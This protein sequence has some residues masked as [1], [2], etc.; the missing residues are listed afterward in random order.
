MSR[1]LALALGP[2]ARYLVRNTAAEVSTLPE[3]CQKLAESIPDERDR[4]EF[5]KYCA[6]GLQASPCGPGPAD[7]PLSRPAAAEGGSAPVAFEPALLH[8]MKKE[9]AHY[10]GPMAGLLVEQAARQARTADELRDLLAARIDSPKDRS[11]WSRAMG[12]LRR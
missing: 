9:L 6:P 7:S 8:A 3:L 12:R 10:L 4:E 5:L 1:Q 2:I 11:D